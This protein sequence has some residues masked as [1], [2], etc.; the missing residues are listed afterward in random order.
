[1]GYGGPQTGYDHKPLRRDRKWIEG[2]YGRNGINL[3]KYLS[4]CSVRH[5]GA[6]GTTPPQDVK[7]KQKVRKVQVLLRRSAQP[8][9][10]WAVPLSCEAGVPGSE[11]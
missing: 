8:L 11:G 3:F 1:M 2:W 9:G 7:N 6:V 10:G 4:R 5:G